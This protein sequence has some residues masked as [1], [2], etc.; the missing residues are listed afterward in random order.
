VRGGGDLRTLRLDRTGPLSLAASRG[1]AGTA[2]GPGARY[3][4]LAAPAATV[5]LRPES[6]PPVHVRDAAGWIGEFSRSAEGIRFALSSYAAT[7]FTL[8]SARGCRTR[9][10]EREAVPKSADGDEQHYEL[11]AVETATTPRRYVVDVRCGA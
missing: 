1:V 9:I 7:R 11:P 10:D 3:L 4:H 8:G 6:R 2:P 5:V